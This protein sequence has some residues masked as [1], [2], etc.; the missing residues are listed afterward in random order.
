MNT[1]SN[2]SDMGPQNQFNSPEYSDMEC[3]SNESIIAISRVIPNTP[4]ELPE[5]P[6]L[7]GISKDA[8]IP[9][10]VR[11]KLQEARELLAADIDWVK[12]RNTLPP[13]SHVK[14]GTMTNISSKRKFKPSKNQAKKKIC[15]TFQFSPEVNEGE[16]GA[17]FPSVNESNNGHPI[18][19]TNDHPVK[20][21]EIGGVTN[22]HENIVPSPNL[23]TQEATTIPN[24]NIS[25]SNQRT[26]INVFSCLF[27]N[28]N[29]KSFMH[30]NYIGK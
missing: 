14:I 2:T 13:K 15:Q 10:Y 21:P 4:P 26:P 23:D 7:E 8:C 27:T 22:H 18:N 3:S 30:E 20:I 29:S 24:K 16:S 25:T 12:S 17:L 1:N 28:S 9:Q 6:I 5:A 19:T 11:E